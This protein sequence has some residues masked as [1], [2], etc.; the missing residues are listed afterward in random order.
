MRRAGAL[1]VQPAAGRDAATATVA[2]VA[3]TRRSRPVV[4]PGSRTWSGPPE[5]ADDS[6]RLDLDRRRSD[7]A[8][9]CS[10]QGRI[11]MA[12]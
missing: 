8:I 7:A 3:A 6:T 10:D 12:V 11:A 5:R 4:L 1:R 9:V 2:T